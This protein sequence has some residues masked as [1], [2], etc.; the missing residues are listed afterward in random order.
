[1]FPYNQTSTQCHHAKSCHDEG[2][3]VKLMMKRKTKRRWGSDLQR[4]PSR[5]FRPFAFHDY[6]RFRFNSNKF[7]RVFLFSIVVLFTQPEWK[8]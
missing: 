1:M 7:E 3:F 5:R 6:C 8:L 4:F 2:Y